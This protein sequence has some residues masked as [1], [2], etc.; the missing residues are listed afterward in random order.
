MYNEEINTIKDNTLDFLVKFGNSNRL[1]QIIHNIARKD[2]KKLI[3]PKLESICL[4]SESKLLGPTF[5]ICKQ[6]IAM[7]TVEAKIKTLKTFCIN[8]WLLLITKEIKIIK[9][10]I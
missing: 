7:G 6:A 9:I 3:L 2:E 1:T 8:N 4:L 5:K 10:E